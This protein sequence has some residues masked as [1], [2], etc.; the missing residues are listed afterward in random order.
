L[1]SLIP[2]NGPG[3]DSLG[4]AVVVRKGER[5]GGGLDVEV[6]A[7]G[8]GVDVGQAGDACVGDPLPELVVVARVGSQEGGEGADEGGQGGHLGAGGLDA[9]ECFLPAGGEVVRPGEQGP[10]GLAR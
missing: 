5:R 7:A 10:G 3:V 2:Q 4:A 8:E 9:C 6:E 1:T